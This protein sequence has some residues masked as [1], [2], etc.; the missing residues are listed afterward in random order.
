VRTTFVDVFPGT[1]RR[2][3]DRVAVVDGDRKASY[4]ELLD[5]SL[6]LASRLVELLDGASNQPV[7]VLLPKSYQSVAADLG[8]LL[9]A[10]FYMNLDVKSPEHRLQAILEQVRPAVIISTRDIAGQFGCLGEEGQRLLLL[11]EDPWGAATVDEPALARRRQLVIDT[12]PMCIINTSGSTGTPKSVVL[13]HRSFIDF[14]AWAVEDQ[15]LGGDEVL[16][17]LSP[18]VF[19]IY[20]F[21]L[22][23]MMEL[24][25]TFV[26]LPDS[27]AAF[28]ARLLDLVSANDVT[29]LFWVPTILVNIANADLLSRIPLPR[30]R[31]LWFAGEVFPTRQFNYWRRMLPGARTTNL[32]GP[33]EITLDCT[34]LTIEQEWPE[35]QPLPIGYACTNTDVL[36]L[37]GDRPCAPGEEGEL[38]VRG[39]SLAMG[40]YNDPVK[41]SRA[42]VQNPLNTSYPELIYRTGDIVMREESGLIHFRGRRDTLVKHA[43]YRIELTEIEH[44]IVS[45]L[46]IVTN[47]CA[48]YDHAAK[49]IVFVYEAEDDISVAE[50]R[51]RLG[52]DLPRYMVPGRL[53]RV[54]EMPRNTNGKIDRLR[55]AGQVL[56]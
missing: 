36:V 48:I 49:Q 31:F 13:N 52:Q 54:P 4:G 25:S 14:T 53:L 22:C 28:P 37:D 43:G 23:M 38:C 40:Y 41:T 27:V 51:S 3:S 24:G 45:N 33:I 11:D 39:T 6:H 9:A 15:G 29:F 12:D 34:A 21:E 18:T 19:D 10:D 5:D 17:S 1:A 30:L 32:Y 26:V 2:H 7:G 20:S 42:F 35:D 47:G 56:S 8:V 44:V 16:G 46:Q 50:F 55:L